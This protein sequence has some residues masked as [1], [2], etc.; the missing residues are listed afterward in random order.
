[1]KREDRLVENLNSEQQNVVDR[2]E[3]K[4]AVNPNPRANENL[5]EENKTEKN[6]ETGSEITDGEA[7]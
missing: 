2:G 6:S 5:P 3:K 1:M 7:G 4:I